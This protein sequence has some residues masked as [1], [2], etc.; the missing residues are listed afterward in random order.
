MRGICFEQ[1]EIVATRQMND[2]VIE[3]GNDAIVTVQ[4]SG[5]CGSDLHPFFGRETGMDAGTVM[6]HEFVGQVVETGDEVRTV[7]KGDRVCAPFTTSCGECFYCKQGLTARCVQGQLFGWRSGGVGLHGAQAELVRVPL[8]DGTLVKL[9]ED[10]PDEVAL[11]VGDNL[12]TGYFC[13]EMAASIKT[14][15]TSS[16]AAAPSVC[17]VYYLVVSWAPVRCWPMT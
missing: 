5:L 12:S 1:V 17:F 13:A 2:P 15:S 11:L 6:G 14:V 9:D 8:A 7:R 16:L 4:L 3:H 10:M